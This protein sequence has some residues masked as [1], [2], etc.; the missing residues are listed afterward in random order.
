MTSF[1]LT[2]QSQFTNII[3]ITQVL[4]EILTNERFETFSYTNYPAKLTTN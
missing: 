3:K 4:Y 2:G 1:R